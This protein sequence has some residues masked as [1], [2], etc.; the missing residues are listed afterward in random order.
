[1]GNAG[2]LHHHR[3]NFDKYHP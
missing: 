2:C 1:R 3:I